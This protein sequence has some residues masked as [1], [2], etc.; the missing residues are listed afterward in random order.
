MSDHQSSKTHPKIR[1]RRPNK[2]RRAS[3]LIT[4]LSIPGPTARPATAPPLPTI[5]A[6]DGTPK[7]IPLG[8]I[9][10]EV[11]DVDVML[12]DSGSDFSMIDADVE[13]VCEPT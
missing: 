13:S 5:I 4:A 12:E 9:A 1:R 2:S 6:D 11:H 8:K 10:D 7:G 3:E